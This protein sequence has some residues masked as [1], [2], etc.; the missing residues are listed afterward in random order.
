MESTT[1]RNDLIKNNARK[2]MKDLYLL[3]DE[4]LK[5]EK[6]F[7]ENSLAFTKLR[8]GENV[9]D[10]LSLFLDSRQRASL[11]QALKDQKEWRS[12]CLLI[13]E[14]SF[15]IKML[16]H[17]VDGNAQPALVFQKE[18][19]PLDAAS[20]HNGFAPAESPA[21]N[22]Q[23]IN[24]ILS[25]EEDNMGTKL[26]RFCNL[27][28][29]FFHNPKSIFVQV[30]YGAN[31]Y[32]DYQYTEQRTLQRLSFNTGG[33]EC[34][35]VIGQKA[36]NCHD[37]PITLAQE[38]EQWANVLK[39][40]VKQF[41]EKEFYKQNYFE[42]TKKRIR[43]NETLLRTIGQHYPSGSI[44]LINNQ[45]DI[46]Y[47]D[48]EEEH[49]NGYDP[50][51]IIGRNFFE[52]FTPEVQRESQKQSREKIDHIL[53][54]NSTSYERWFDGKYYYYEGKPVPDP[55]TGQNMALIISQEVTERKKL[56]A[57]LKDE[58]NFSEAI[59]D[60]LPDFFHMVDENLHII[61]WNENFQYFSGYSEDEIYQ[62][63]SLDFFAP[64]EHPKLR[65]TGQKTFQE[66][67]MGLIET[68]I[69]TKSGERR[70]FHLSGTLMYRDRKPYLLAIGMDISRQ[71][72]LEKQ[73]KDSLREKETLLKEIHH[74]VKNNLTIIQSLLYMKS[75]T[76]EN[77]EIREHFQDSQ[78]RIRSIAL[79][80]EKLYESDSLA[81]VD[82]KN[83]IEDLGRELEN[84]LVCP[85]S[86]GE[87]NIQA[88]PARL[89][90]NKAVPCGLLINEL[91]TNA[92]EHG[93]QGP[94]SCGKVDLFCIDHNEELEITIQD[95]GPGFP[96]KSS[97]DESLGLSLIQ[98]L[99]DQLEGTLHFSSENGARVTLRFPKND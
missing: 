39:N 97:D 41:L 6:V 37:V 88:D 55:I 38:E 70:P 18:N 84:S 73:L 17:K 48:G 87:L 96:Q 25:K 49:N 82:I 30:Q 9:F 1:A 95:Y 59:I 66:G 53:A 29:R 45:Y 86:Q 14:Q 28:P 60:N 21:E 52:V 20:S 57:T 24:E 31:R 2:D 75:Q 34:E 47:I 94:D 10:G 92:I 83:Y 65:E 22:L 77:P 42:N 54:G 44:T 12:N 8:E 27:A 26:Q 43:E 80:H 36:E 64:E 7:P 89:N 62:K 56:E 99:A 67:E 93:L 63:N 74:R 16:Y 69:L 3:L 15:S 46:Y 33:Y 68:Q 35:L 51:E 19:A 4:D 78:A 5:I 76:I 98:G 71:K 72:A 58:K 11:Q 32:Y 79:V 61:K 23:R 85:D 90:I 40:T 91:L 81:D 13:G 50:N